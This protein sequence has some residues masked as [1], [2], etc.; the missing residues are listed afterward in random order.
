MTFENKKRFSE[1]IEKYRINNLNHKEYM[2][3]IWLLG[4]QETESDLEELLNNYWKEDKSSEISDSPLAVPFVKKKKRKVLWWS[5]IAAS[6]IFAVVA[7]IHINNY[8]EIIGQREL[9]FKTD[10]GERL[11]ID[12]DDGSRVTLNAN[13]SL[14]WT[15]NWKKNAVRQVSLEGE[16]FFEVKKQKSIP[17]NVKTNDVSIEVL[18]TSFNVNSRE[19]TTTVYL[20]NGKVNLK[21]MDN[22]FK[23]NN[24]P[25]KINEIILNPGE[26]IS[27][28]TK[29]GKIEKSEGQSIISAAAWKMNILNLKNMQFS[30]VL[31]L[32]SNIY[33]QSFECSDESLL[34]KTLYLGVPYSDWDAVRHA[35]ELSLDIRFEKTAERHYEVNNN[36]TNKK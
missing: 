6:L 34:S 29:A 10:F 36:T 30:E 17:F 20:E 16:A 15:E 27:Y 26:Q 13:S 31:E 18:G 23:E 2:E 4:E 12:L 8:K 28:N 9:V 5:G 11:E 22:S 33:G 19:T 21:L 14:R 7:F 24:E 25:E 32:L 3:L 1:L 35:L